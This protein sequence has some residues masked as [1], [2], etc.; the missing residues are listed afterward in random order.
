MEKGKNIFQSKYMVPI[1][2]LF[3]CFLWGVPFLCLKL[4]I[5]RWL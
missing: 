5:G 1:L 3:A 2:A 4:V